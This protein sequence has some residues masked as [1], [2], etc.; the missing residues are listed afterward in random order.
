M[1]GIDT[2]A[3]SLEANRLKLLLILKEEHAIDIESLPDSDPFKMFI[4]SMSEMSSELRD[5]VANQKLPVKH[6]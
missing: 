6:K 4:N 2:L 5:S 1:R 3:K